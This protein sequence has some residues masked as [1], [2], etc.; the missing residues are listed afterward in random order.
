MNQANRGRTE[1]SVPDQIKNTVKIAGS[2]NFAF[3]ELIG[4]NMGRG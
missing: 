1:K 2:K 3:K 4:V